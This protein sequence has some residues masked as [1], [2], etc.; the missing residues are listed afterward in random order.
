MAGTLTFKVKGRGKGETEAY[1]LRAEVKI[2]AKQQGIKAPKQISISGEF[3]NNYDICY[4][5]LAIKQ[6]ILQIAAEWKL[7]SL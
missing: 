6:L 1:A 4:S 5:S 7:K 3:Y 2:R